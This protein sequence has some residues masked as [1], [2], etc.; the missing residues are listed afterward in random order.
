MKSFSISA[1]IVI[2]ALIGVS[3]YAATMDSNHGAD[4]K[5]HQSGIHSAPPDN[6]IS[7]ELVPAMQRAQLANMRSHL[8]AVQL[9][10]GLMAANEFEQASRIANS[11]LGMTDEMR[12]MCNSFANEDFKNLGLAFHES[13]N[14]L[15][16]AL[17]TKD[18]DSSLQALGNT[19]GFCVQCHAAFRQ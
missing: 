7:L 10:V 14:A 17:Q 3:S 13:G 8:E 15:G 4:H 12:Q 5:M 18:V 1:G 2:L 9:I 19:M 16:D 6:R 11:K